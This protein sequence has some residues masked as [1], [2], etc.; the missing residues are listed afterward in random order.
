MNLEPNLSWTLVVCN[1]VYSNDQD[2]VWHEFVPDKVSA[3][4]NPPPQ[5]PIRQCEICGIPLPG[6]SAK[7]RYGEGGGVYCERHVN[8]RE[9]IDLQ[10]RRKAQRRKSN[11]SKSHE[12]NLVRLKSQAEAKG[13]WQKAQYYQ[14]QLNEYQEARDSADTQRI[15]LVIVFVIMVGTGLAQLPSCTM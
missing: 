14:M 7:Y 9:A 12:E 3:P 11:D 5:E 1:A 15:M 4:L 8:T 6:N 10:E 13:E 2:P